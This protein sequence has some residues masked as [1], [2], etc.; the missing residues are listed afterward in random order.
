MVMVVEVEVGLGRIRRR[1][2]IL[3]VKCFTLNLTFPYLYLFIY[4]SHL[5]MSTN[6]KYYWA[7]QICWENVEKM[8]LLENPLN[9]GEP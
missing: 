9:I 3:F 4:V 2:D 1:L 6:Q 5:K 7:I 8:Q